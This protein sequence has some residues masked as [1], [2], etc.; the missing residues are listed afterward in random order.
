MAEIDAAVA[1]GMR[2]MRAAWPAGS[3]SS[4]A[5]RE[6]VRVL[7]GARA[8]HHIG[9]AITQLI[10]EHEDRFPPTVAKV[11]QALRAVAGKDP[12]PKQDSGVRFV[13]A[14]PDGRDR[15]GTERWIVIQPDGRRIPEG[16]VT[17]DE[18][19]NRSGRAAG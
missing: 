10:D 4:D 3:W 14:A 18:Y 17:M 12:K 19:M 7:S 9:T 8:R 6:Y 1:A 11:A 2:R 13:L 15:P 5:A 16:S